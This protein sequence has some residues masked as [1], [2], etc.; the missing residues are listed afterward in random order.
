M[1]GTDAEVVDGIRSRGYIAGID[2]EAVAQHFDLRPSLCNTADDRS[3]LLQG[4]GEHLLVGGQAHARKSKAAKHIAAG[5]GFA[6]GEVRAQAGQVTL[7]VGV[8]A[9]PL[10][11]TV[12]ALAQCLLA[13]QAPGTQVDPTVQVEVLAAC[14]APFAQAAVLGRYLIVDER[15]IDARVPALL[16][17]VARAVLA[18]GNLWDRQRQ[19]Q[20]RRVEVDTG[21]RD[22]GCQVD[23]AII[24]GQGCLK[25]LLAQVQGTQ[26]VAGQAGLQATTIGSGME[27]QLPLFDGGKVYQQ[28]NAIAPCW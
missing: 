20:L 22:Q 14:V 6:Q 28:G 18:Q 25:R 7:G 26:H 15:C 27:L 8:A 13:A 4:I 21:L 5:K 23:T 17:H 9:A 24:L 16:R 2:R 12:I 11:C 10:P 19:A 1:T 3:I